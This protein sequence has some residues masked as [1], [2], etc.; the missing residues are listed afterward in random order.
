VKEDQ[1]TGGSPEKKKKLAFRTGRERVRTERKKETHF[2]CLVYGK[3]GAEIQ[4][5]K[6]KKG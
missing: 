3:R 1:A 5:P 6:T 2:G 4:K